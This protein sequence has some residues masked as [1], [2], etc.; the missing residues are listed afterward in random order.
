MIN[1]GIVPLIKGVRTM[2]QGS[3]FKPLARAVTVM[4]VVMIL[5]S[6]VTFAALQSQQAVLTGYNCRATADL[7]IS[8]DG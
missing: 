1:G 3:T 2:R 5:V 6:G 7:K 4:A 8:T